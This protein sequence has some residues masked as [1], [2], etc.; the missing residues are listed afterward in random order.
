MIHQ[1]N[2]MRAWCA[3]KLRPKGCNHRSVEIR[4]D[5]NIRGTWEFNVAFTKDAIIIRLHSWGWGSVAST[6]QTPSNICFLLYIVSVINALT[7]SNAIHIV[8]KKKVNHHFVHWYYRTL[9]LLVNLIPNF[10]DCLSKQT[11][12]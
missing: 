10:V 5:G 8:I 12:H 11:L 3:A 2:I 7:N 6:S 9:T 4:S 1:R